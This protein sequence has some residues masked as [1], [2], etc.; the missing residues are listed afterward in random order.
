MSGPAA[1][2]R[3]YRLT[4]FMAAE[5]PPLLRGGSSVSDPGTE[6][7]WQ[8]PGFSNFTLYQ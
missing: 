1:F 5:R 6:P 3:Q 2:A 4:N 8:D 7:L